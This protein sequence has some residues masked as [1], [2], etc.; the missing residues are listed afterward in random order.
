MFG[1][2]PARRLDGVRRDSV[3]RDSPVADAVALAANTIQSPIHIRQKSFMALVVLGSLVRVTVRVFDMP[4]PSRLHDL[5]EVREARLPPK[6]GRG[7]LGG[8]DE[9]GRISRTA[10]FLHHCDGST[11]NPPAGFDDFAH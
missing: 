4:I 9:A 3:G 7:L 10:V 11:R 8:G 2:L 6:F 5:V 1:R